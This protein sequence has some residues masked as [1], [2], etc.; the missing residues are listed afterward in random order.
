ME[1]KVNAAELNDFWGGKNGEK[2]VGTVWLFELY[3]V[4]V[5]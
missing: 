4:S 5:Y 3:D 1:F 2:N